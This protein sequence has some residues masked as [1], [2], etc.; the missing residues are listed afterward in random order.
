MGKYKA[1]I[2]CPATANTVAKLAHGIADSLITNSAAQAMKV[3]VPVYIY[4]VDQKPGTVVT[5]LPD[6]RDLTIRIRDVDIKNV[7][8][9]KDMQG[10]TVLEKVEQLKNVITTL[11]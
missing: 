5:K 8:I 2:I 6:G 7:E 4:P 1:F 11:L 10:I 3:D 9:L